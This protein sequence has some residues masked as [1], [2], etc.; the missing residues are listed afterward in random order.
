MG[1]G[2]AEIKKNFFLD[3]N[4]RARE[5]KEGAWHAREMNTKGWYSRRTI[6]AIRA[7]SDAIVAPRP[8]K[9]PG[10]RHDSPLAVEPTCD[11]LLSDAHQTAPPRKRVLSRSTAIPAAKR[12][13][14]R[15][16]PPPPDDT[17]QEDDRQQDRR[18]CI[19]DEHGKS[20]PATLPHCDP[21]CAGGDGAAQR[22]RTDDYDDDGSADNASAGD[23]LVDGAEYDGHDDH[24]GHSDSHSTTRQGDNNNSVDGND[25]MQS[26]NV[27]DDYIDAVGR[28]DSQGRQRRSWSDDDRLEEEEAPCRRAHCAETGRATGDTSRGTATTDNRKDD[29]EDGEDV[30]TSDDDDVDDDDEPTAED[31]RR[32]PAAA[33]AVG[34]RAEAKRLERLCRVNEA[35]WRQTESALQAVR[36]AIARL[37]RMAARGD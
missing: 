2:M 13:C 14:D 25:G 29:G 35:V 30:Y 9:D 32:S 4:S 27:D 6:V 31:W 22:Q 26:D 18:G 19:G 11:D 8:A 3:K 28:R 5:T 36:Y 1:T 20:P 21:D 7:T 34:L 17:Q 16:P 33:V 15:S 37:D 23:S 24:G 10:R 12:P